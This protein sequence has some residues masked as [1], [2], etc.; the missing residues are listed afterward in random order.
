MKT[1]NNALI[2]IRRSPY[3]SLLAVFVITITFFVGYSFSLALLGANQVLEFFET[4]PQVI[5]FFKLNA[6][7]QEID[8]L[9]QTMQQKPYV[10]D[11]KT[12][13]KQEALTIYQQSNKDNP[14]LLELVT[15]DILP[16]SIELSATK[17]DALEQIKND[18]NQ[19]NNIEE[20][21]Y[22]KDIIDD[23]YQWSQS[24]RIIGL[25]STAVLAA[26]SFLVM[27]IIIG[28]KM[29]HKK[30]AIS[31][32]KIIGASSGYIVSPFLLEGIIYGILGSLIGFLGMYLLLL[33]LTPMIRDFVGN[34]ITLPVP[35]EVLGLQLAIGTLVGIVLGSLASLLA[36]TKMLHK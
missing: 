21:V 4:S 8:Q 26:I 25:T 35:A 13:T 10:K 9:R 17:I 24:I 27:M 31:I 30:R 23:L 3:Q 28:M 2:N 18:L 6:K 22:Q 5:G 14:L 11:V 1:L 7:A 19:D 12:I 29:V 36:T 20:A 15:A 34:I 16:A 33:Y 32:M